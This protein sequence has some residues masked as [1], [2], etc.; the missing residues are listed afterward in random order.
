MVIRDTEKHGS[1]LGL[2]KYY[3]WKLKDAAQLDISK[4][5]DHGDMESAPPSITNSGSVINVSP[6]VERDKCFKQLRE[7]NENDA[8][9]VIQSVVRRSQARVVHCRSLRVTI[10]IQ[11]A[12]R[13]YRTRVKYFCSLG[14]ARLIQAVTRRYQ[15]QAAYCCSLRATIVIQAAARRTRAWVPRHRHLCA[16][17]LMKAWARGCKS[18][19]FYKKTLMQESEDCFDDWVWY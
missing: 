10:S 13:C 9:I 5:L 3:V 19:S 11:S 7:S 4:H 6:P 18:R 17:V 1:E 16:I 15:R 12:V 8:A 2:N 14:A